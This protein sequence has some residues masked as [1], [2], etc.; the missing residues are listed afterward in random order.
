MSAFVPEHERR[1]PGDAGGAVI[2]N[3]GTYIA[4]S[5][6]T[7]EKGK[8]P[9]SI[10]VRPHSRAALAAID[11]WSTDDGRSRPGRRYRRNSKHL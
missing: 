4:D 1:A 11:R 7:S 10:G 9:A 2:A 5:G 6:R 8:R 3:V